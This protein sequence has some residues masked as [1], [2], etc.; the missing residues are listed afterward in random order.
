MARE[1]SVFSRQVQNPSSFGAHTRTGRPWRR[2][3]R[4]SSRAVL[5][6]GFAAGAVA[7]C[8]DDRIVFRDRE[9][10]NPPPAA[11]EGFLGYYDASAKQTTCGN[12]HAG[13]QGEW[14][15]SGH[16]GAMATLDGSGHAQPFCYV[17][18]TVNGNGN[19]AANPA[20]WAAVEDE[21][22]QDVQC[23]SCHG[24]GLTHVEG[25]GQGQIVRPLASISLA[26]DG[27]CGDCH[28]GAHHPFVDEWEQSSHANVSASRAS[29]PSCVGCH[30][31]RGALARWGIDAN[32]QERD[33][34]T[35]YQPI[36][37]AVCHDPHGSPN[38]AQLRF[39]V[40]A[41]D[42]D[43][44]LCMKCH[45][46]RGEP[47]VSVTSPHA[48]QGA[49]L[50]GFA[51]WRPP[52]FAYD[53]ARIF[54]SH[55]TTK[56]PELCAGCHVGQFTVTDQI[57]GDF[58]FQATGHLFRAVPCLDAT[59]KPTAD[60]SCAYTTAARSWQ[61]CTTAG[62][63]SSDTIAVNLFNTVRARMKFYTDQLWQNLDGDG[64]LDAAPVD[65][66]LLAQIKA[67]NPGEFTTADFEVTPAEGAEFNARLCGEYGQSTS[68][69]SKGVHNPFL[70]ESLLIASINYLRIHYS[71][72]TPAPA[73]PPHM[74]VPSPGDLG[75][76]MHI[77]RTP[78]GR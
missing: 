76:S 75:G 57:S 15:Q 36:T 37:C 66:G 61:T 51:G 6:I 19:D 63:H 17:C 13:F 21:V 18:H 50:L 58:A 25:V 59:G 32:Y 26:G 38:Q 34:A 39:P 40:T 46:R 29:N 9:P 55:A 7:G 3:F 71:I 78:P 31:G 11:A 41:P 72:T 64:T 5:L 54:G 52:G 73:V 27:N 43:Q 69:N 20:G 48:P 2:L 44:N 35:A 77:A 28:S 42:P 65:A 33:S 14:R 62:C 16:A 30:E 47:S 45:L 1:R 22:Y 60:E 8:S 70:C 10:F 56:N 12:C 24:P 67:S 53:T 74:L 68:D 23:E 49:V 4:R